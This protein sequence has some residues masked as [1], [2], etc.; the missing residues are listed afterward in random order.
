M[1]T[2]T[3]TMEDIVFDELKE[4][5]AAMHAI[6]TID[7]VAPKFTPEQWV[8]EYHKGNMLD[9]IRQR[10]LQKILELQQDVPENLIQ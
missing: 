2:I 5:T 8:K 10:R 3:L 7:G 1:I 6:P 9:D 4:S